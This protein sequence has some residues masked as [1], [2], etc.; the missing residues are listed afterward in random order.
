MVSE[1][2]VLG[3]VCLGMAS[4]AGYGYVST[5]RRVAAVEGTET[6]TTDALTEGLVALRGTVVEAAEPLTAPLSGDDA[7]VVE[8]EVE[9][10]S[11]DPDEPEDTT[12]GTHAV[13]FYLEDDGGRVRV[14][15]V[16]VEAVTLSGS[17]H[18]SVRQYADR[19][20]DEELLAGLRRFDEDVR[21]SPTFH[22]TSSAKMAHGATRTS[23]DR[24]YRQRA[25]R[26]GD[27]AYVLGTATRGDD[28]EWVLGR[29]DDG[30]FLISD[31]DGEALAD[32]HGGNQTLLLGVVVVLLGVAAYAFANGAGLV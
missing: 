10:E 25:L 3:V 16:N 31:M 29:G 9:E 19:A 13:D 7:V 8:W 17:K 24:R 21:D 11:D 4:I 28:G 12:S 2:T 23:R 22:H 1:T 20:L 27:E 15:P 30:R 32:H 6:V 26:P 5:R 18:A 14:R